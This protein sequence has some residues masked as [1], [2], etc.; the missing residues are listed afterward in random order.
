MQGQ[1]PLVGIAAQ[2]WKNK[3]A[4]KKLLQRAYLRSSPFL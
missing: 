4:A 1:D 3:Q 2:R